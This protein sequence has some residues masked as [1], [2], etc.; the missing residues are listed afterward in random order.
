M[1]ACA[2]ISEENLY[3]AI[4]I[5]QKYKLAEIRLDLCQF[6]S[7]EI[8]VVFSGHNN[9]IATYRNGT[10]SAEKVH[11][12]KRAID[13]G[14]AY[15]DIEANFDKEYRDE[16]IE[17]AKA[18]GTGIVYSYHNYQSMD[19]ISSLRDIIKQGKSFG[20]KYIKI[21]VKA[22]TK[23][24]VLSLMN[25]YLEFD[26]LVAF[27]L[28]DKMKYGRIMSVFLGAPYAYVYHGYRKNQL[29]EGQLSNKEFDD[30]MKN[31]TSS[32]PS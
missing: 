25:L 21:A 20:A 27:P 22:S 10:S 18:R 6:T 14:A 28:G 9:L 19:D 8:N 15:V 26:N 31:L 23:E 32:R 11:T 12:L 24:E 5:A 16:I 30:V 17:Y 3:K 29:A 1:L 13:A 2:T 4:S 7:K